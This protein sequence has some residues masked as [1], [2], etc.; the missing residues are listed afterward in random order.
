[1]E[2]QDNIRHVF[3][4]TQIEMA[5]LLKVSRA[6]YSMYES[7]K[8]SLPKHARDFLTKMFEQVKMVAA[9]DHKKL[10]HVVLQEIEMKKELQEMLKEN[11]YKRYTT[12]KK[13]EATERKYN[14]HVKA[15]QLVNYL[16]PICKVEDGPNFLGVIEYTAKKGVAHNSLVK[17]G[18]LRIRLQSLQYEQTLIKA[19]LEEL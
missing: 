16:E 17:L 14:A 9:D 12:T 5:M 1:M 3:G 11:E 4:L 7:V 6:R 13:L 10:P 18:K 19:T 15:L 8:R 2:K